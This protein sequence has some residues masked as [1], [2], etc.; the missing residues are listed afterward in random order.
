M[1]SKRHLGFPIVALSLMTA[2]QTVESQRIDLTT[3]APVI[4]YQGQG[5]SQVQYLNDLQDC[6][7]IG[8]RVQAQY[9]E[10]RKKEQ[11]QAVTSA[12]IGG[13][14]GAAIG[15][16]V[17]QQ[18]DYHSGRAATAGAAYGAAIGGS[19]GVDA[20]DYSRVIAKFGGSAVIDKCMIGRGYQVISIEGY[21]GG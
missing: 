20:I 12:I 15:H 11:E 10:Q 6:R 17:G 5:K 7:S 16:S 9:E 3:Y 21:G 19:S 4:D 1:N 2:C 13:L 14:I 18:N 8:L